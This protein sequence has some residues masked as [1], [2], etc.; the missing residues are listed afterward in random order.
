MPGSH[1]TKR[2]ICWGNREKGDHSSQPF[3]RSQ[4]RWASPATSVPYFSLFENLRFKLWVCFTGFLSYWETPH[5]RHITMWRHRGGM[6][7]ACPGR[8]ELSRGEF[9]HEQHVHDKWAMI[10]SCMAEP[11]TMQRLIQNASSAQ[12]SW[13]FFICAECPRHT[14]LV[15]GGGAVQRTRRHGGF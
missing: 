9:H 7:C 8:L 10:V 13:M 11:S 12:T 14:C 2:G 4:R 5:Q 1:S 6:S 3:C 15:Q